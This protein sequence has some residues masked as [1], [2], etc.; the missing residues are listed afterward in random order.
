MHTKDF[1][2]KCITICVHEYLSFAEIIHTPD[3]H[4]DM[5][6]KQHDYDVSWTGN[7]IRQL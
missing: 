5:L 4:V 6:N 7:N 2:H 3:R 1:V